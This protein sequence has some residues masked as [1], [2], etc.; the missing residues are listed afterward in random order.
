MKISIIGYGKMG[1][2]IQKI[3]LDRGHE[4]HVVIDADNWS[5]ES[6]LGS[7]VAIEF[8]QPESAKKNMINCFK[9]NVPVVIGTTG[10]YADYDEVVLECENLE[11]ALLA[12]TNFSL[13]V[14]IFFEINKKLATLMS[15]NT[16]YKP[17]ITETHHIQKL[18]RP[19]G[20]AIS[21]A[22][23]IIEKHESFKDW[24]LLDNLG[25]NDSISI[26]SNREPN[27]AG[28]HTVIFEDDIDEIA[29]THSAKNR[30]GFALGAVLAAEFLANKKGIFTMKEVLGI[31]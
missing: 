27:V 18:D 24:N 1:Q 13:G 21:L 30:K 19:S 2:Q 22:E 5:Q 28:K 3:A 26:E 8:T 29:I 23:Q 17:T 14:N 7:D 20:T 15:L 12:S 16:N 31:Q 11:G 9:A 10:W 6:I 25:S 4:I